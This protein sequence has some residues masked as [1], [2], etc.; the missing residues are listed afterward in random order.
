MVGTIFCDFSLRDGIVFVTSKLTEAL[1]A[2]QKNIRIAK[3][4]EITPTMN[5]ESE[6]ISIGTTAVDDVALQSDDGLPESDVSLQSCNECTEEENELL[7]CSWVSTSQ[8]LPQ[9]GN[10]EFPAQEELTTKC[11]RCS[12]DYMQKL[13]K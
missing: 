1:P 10:Q 11:S 2:D 5:E 13:L 8:P 4:Y 9:S 3:T 7:E 12:L 6:S